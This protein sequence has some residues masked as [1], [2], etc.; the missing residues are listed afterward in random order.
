VIFIIAAESYIFVIFYK[1]R[2]CLIMKKYIHKMVTIF[3]VALVFMH[4]ALC[5]DSAGAT[6]KK[7]IKERYDAYKKR[8]GTSAPAKT[9][10]AAAPAAGLST[11]TL[12]QAKKAAESAFIVEKNKTVYDQKDFSKCG[13]YMQDYIKAF[14][15][16]ETAAKKEYDAATAAIPVSSKKSGEVVMFQRAYTNA[17]NDIRPVTIPEPASK[18]TDAFTDAQE[19]AKKVY[20]KAIANAPQ[21]VAGFQNASQNALAA[22]KKALEP[23]NIVPTKEA[24]AFATSAFRAASAIDKSAFYGVK[25]Q[26]FNAEIIGKS[27][28]DV[29]AITMKYRLAEYQAKIQ[30]LPITTVAPGI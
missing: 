7:T 17:E 30:G 21:D 25:Q 3:F 23:A 2:K 19:E 28:L 16:I 12:T 26:K 18:V 11:T 20:D 4:S 13:V 8:K 9:P 10:A 1:L 14:R 6:A 24:K 5:V 22:Y 15:V 27:A 29:Y